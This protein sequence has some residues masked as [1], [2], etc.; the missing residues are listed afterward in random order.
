MGDRKLRHYQ[1]ALAIK[2]EAL[3]DEDKSKDANDVAGE[4][5]KKNRGY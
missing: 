5:L 1:K 3:I 2:Q 4:I